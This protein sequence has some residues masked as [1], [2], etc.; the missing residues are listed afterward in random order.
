MFLINM[1][2]CSNKEVASTWLIGADK[3]MSECVYGHGRNNVL[4]HELL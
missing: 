2:L 4:N 1:C 3:G